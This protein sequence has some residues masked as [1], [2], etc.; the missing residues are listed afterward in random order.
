MQ[1]SLFYSLLNKPERMILSA[2]ANTV[3]AGLEVPDK[4]SYVADLGTFAQLVPINSDEYFL[5]KVQ[6]L[7]YIFYKIKRFEEEETNRPV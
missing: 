7:M 3:P 2:F 1:V 5:N 4:P 6:R